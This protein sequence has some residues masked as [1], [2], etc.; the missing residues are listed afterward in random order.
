[1]GQEFGQDIM[2]MTCLCS[3]M[4]RASSGKIN[5]WWL[6]DSWDL[7]SPGGVAHMTGD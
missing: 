4:S 2:G 6:L 3:I 1:M 7:K 5:G